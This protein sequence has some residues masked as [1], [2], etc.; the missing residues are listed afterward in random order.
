[1]KSI[2]KKVI[3][4]LLAIVW[5]VSSMQAQV[6]MSNYITLTVQK[7]QSIQFDLKAASD[8]TPIRVVSGNQTT[9]ITANVVWMGFKNFV[10]DETTMT[11]YGDVTGFDCS[12]NGDK[13]Y[14][15]DAS[16]NKILKGLYCNFNKIPSLN[17]SGLTLLEELGCRKNQLSS[18]NVSGCTALI[19]LDCYSNSLS[20]L[21]VSGLTALTKLYC[22]NNQLSSLKVNGCTALKELYC[23][24]NQLS[25]LDANKLTALTI[26]FC[27]ENKLSSL[28]VK[29]CKALKALD[30]Y[31]N[32]LSSLDIS[33]L[34][35]LERLACYS[36]KLSSLD[37]ARSTVL[38]TLFCFDN[39]FSTQALDKLYCSLPDRKGNGIGR[40]QP[41]LNASSPDN[42]IVLATNGGNATEKN[43]KIQ[44]YEGDADIT[45]F[46][47]THKCGGDV[48]M[49]RYITLTVTK[50]DDINIS[51]AADAVGTQVKIVSGDKEQTITASTAW[52]GSKKFIAG[53]G[54]MSIYGNVA[55]LNCYKNDKKITALDASHNEQLVF[56][57]CSKNSL[58]SLD[59]S[60]NT[61]LIWLLCT[62]NTIST[63]DL[64]NNTQLKRLTCQKNAITSLD[65]SNNKELVFLSC[66]TNKLTTLDVSNNTQLSAL[67][68]F[69]NQLSSLD[70]SKNTQLSTLYCFDNNLSTVSLDDIYC[71]L[72]DKKGHFAGTI[73]PLLNASSLEKDK[74]L[75][76]NGNN[77][78]SK[79][80]KIQYYEGYSDIKGF[81]GT[82]QC[83]GTGVEEV[84]DTPA[85][86]SVY[87]NPVS[88]I[89][90][91]TTDKPARSIR[92]YNVYGQEV[93]Q[94]T[95]ANSINVANLPAGV[96][97]V[98]AD[99]KIAKVI[100]E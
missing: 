89:L 30:C 8:N 25:S 67:Y 63:L 38:E 49:D 56:L 7:G 94:A 69:A 42:S 23:N 61:K 28:N 3:I 29:G 16:H 59:L 18:L 24:N 60:K 41:V 33:D 98:N 66:H 54:T 11:I 97:I 84:K 20:S 46:T 31:T 62:D 50:G 91:I 78:T 100:K 6:N 32:Q 14:G 43:W 47:G 37:A 45:G 93:A 75:A 77:A 39:K 21:D 35:A 85:V 99:G 79:N 70:I 17:V 22:H 44:Y 48:N 92:V 1:M 81:T 5:G 10:S 95:D 68:C 96:Y 4:A 76:T 12:E 19:S 82:H 58:T 26:L 86:L 34:T 73:K 64:R 90:Y 88:D 87:P 57:D 2:F 80:W 15:L 55:K 9:D 40:I 74:V 65:V 53:A 51:I 83:G 13:I 36:N 71:S 72:P 27:Y 52:S